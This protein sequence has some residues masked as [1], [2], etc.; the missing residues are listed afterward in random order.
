MWISP[1][2]AQ[3]AGGGD[4]IL[5]FLPLVLI[6]V[7][8]YFLL[9]R[10]QMKREKERRKMI[11]AL[12]RG[13]RVVT[14]G[15]LIGTVTKVEDGGTLVLEIAADVRV[16]FDAG[17][18]EALLSKPE[19]REAEPSSRPKGGRRK[20]NQRRKQQDTDQDTDQNGDQ[21]DQADDKRTIEDKRTDDKT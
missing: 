15:G 5:S 20:G 10:P 13:D 12:K 1:A 11:D 9:I 14:Q 3:G 18:V 19:P 21:D 2:Y 4:S 7:V 16:K 17:K 6:F 8:F